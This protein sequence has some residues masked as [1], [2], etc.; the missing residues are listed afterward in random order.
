MNRIDQ[1]FAK[2]RKVFIPYITAGCPTVS[3]TLS[4]MNI[5]VENGA[6]IIELGFPFSDPTADGPV[7]QAAAQHALN[8]RFERNDYFEILTRFRENNKQTPIVVFS[9]INPIFH[10]GI[11]KFCNEARRAGAD[12]MLLVDLPFEEQDDVLP[13]TNA[14]DLHLIQFAAPTTNAIRLRKIV[15]KAAGFI[16]QISVRGVTGARDD[17][18]R[19]ALSMSKLIK[20]LTKVP[21]AV[22]FGISTSDHV[23]SI[24]PN[25]DGIIVGSA[26]V[27]LILENPANYERSLAAKVHELS[28]A[29]H[30]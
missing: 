6:D 7:I 17:V 2:G 23:K 8:N 14:L 9:Y 22:G 20:S 19:D 16:Y 29:I 27:Q 26:I 28:V 15:E 5:L 12:A 13:I 25:A 24:L 11:E 1:V 18:A 21:L 30:E 3:S 4:I 10:Y